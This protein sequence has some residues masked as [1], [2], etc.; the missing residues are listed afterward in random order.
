MRAPVESGASVGHV[1]PRETFW[2]LPNAITLVRILLTPALLLLLW[3]RGPFWSVVLGL[4]FL[5]TSLTD[6]LDGYLARRHQ[7]VTR[8]GK[9]LDPLAD[10]LLV[11]TAVVVLVAAK[12]I[13][14][15]GVPLVIAILGREMAVTGL[16]A[17]ASSEGVVLGAAPMGKWKTG[18][19]IAAI[20]ALLFH[21]PI[22]GVP[23][24][25]LGMILLVVA[26]GLTAWSGYDYFSTFLSRR[27]QEP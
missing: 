12:R 18:L 13:P 23:M 15:W 10:K 2:N 1:P 17:M 19:Q 26:T 27:G 11:M 9:L 22:A 21:Y 16:R 8:M 6:L 25:T 4:G 24:H 14:A 3:F 20:T 5:V 7:T